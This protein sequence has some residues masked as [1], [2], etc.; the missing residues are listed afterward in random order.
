M[1]RRRRRGL[2]LVAA[3]SLCLAGAL[4]P[5]V[6]VSAQEAPGSGFGGFDLAATAPA[7]QVRFED[8][9]YCGGGPAAGCEGVVP[10]ALSR[11]QSGPLGYA[12]S[13]IAWP[14]TLAGNAGSLLLVAG[15]PVPPETAAQF[16]SPVRAESRT[17]Q[18]PA[19]VSNTSVPGATMT[20][21][22]TDTEVTALAALPRTEMALGSVG[23]VSASTRTALTAPSTAVAR[24]ES[25]VTDIAL[26]AGQV[27]IDSITS[28][29][30]A[31]T[32]G[33]T[34]SVSGTTVVQGAT[35]AGVPVT[36]DERGVTV[37][38][39]STAVN[40]VA[41]EAVNAVVRNLGMTVS[42]SRPI[43]TQDGAAVDHSAGSLVLSWTPP[44]SPARMTVVF[45]GSTVT[46]T[47]SPAFATDLGDAGLVT[48]PGGTADLGTGSATVDLPAAVE[49]PVAGNPPDLS[50][51]PLAAPQVAGTSTP[52]T[53][54]AL[55]SQSLDLPAGNGAALVLLGLLGT[56]L[57]AAG[58]R[59]LPDRV[60]AASSAACPI[61]EQR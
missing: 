21:K 30:E 31:T 38:S 59:R 51:A 29:A 12:L 32:D 52:A 57:M 36:I 46:V 34:A 47:A 45:G 2:A 23:S 22:V 55:A 28:T 8:G 17:G 14:G 37:Q 54:T 61:G 39:S 26:A 60:L 35:V 19:E 1:T 56:G 10:E 13:S 40:G 11:L 27:K 41:T 50:G 48:D 24:A 9:G 43:T 15:A 58:L 4:V 42:V 44:Q 5:A 20:A 3:G 25:R 6:A 16:N 33:T 53:R 49:A 7:M 18:Q